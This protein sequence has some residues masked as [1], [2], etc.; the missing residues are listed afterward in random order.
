MA[1]LKTY[2]PQNVSGQDIVDYVNTNAADPAMIAKGMQ[3]YGVSMGDISKAGGWN[4]K[5]IGNYVGGS[6]N[7]YLQ[8]QYAG[9]KKTPRFQPPQAA[10][11]R[12]PAPYRPKEM[13]AMKAA[14][15]PPQTPTYYTPAASSATATYTGDG[16]Y[17]DRLAPYLTD[18]A[19]GK[20]RLQGQIDDITS[21]LGALGPGAD[22]DRMRSTYRDTIRDYGMLMQD[23][24][25]YVAKPEMR[26]GAAIQRP[27]WEPY[28]QVVDQ[29]TP[30]P[31]YAPAISRQGV[32]PTMT[33]AA[34][35]PQA[36]PVQSVTTQAAPQASVQS[37][38]P[39]AKGTLRDAYR[40]PK[41][42]LGGWR[43]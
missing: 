30:T 40:K 38:L 3:D 9:W 41:G 18:P 24:N 8:D 42:L 13:R 14:A 25:A 37:S 22:Q 17:G 31:G 33:Q 19:A 15:M 1:L 10:P 28:Q 29:S 6:G 34:P 36:A 23:L 2:G 21:K 27:K 32:Q 11:A 12:T 39:S 16:G 43:G 7:D 26:A 5:T 4:R 35:T 20:T